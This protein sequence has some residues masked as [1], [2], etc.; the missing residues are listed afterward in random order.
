MWD[1]LACGIG[2]DFLMIEDSHT[3]LPFA[4]VSAKAELA[5]YRELT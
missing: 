2:G 5:R 3:L 1:L 4:H